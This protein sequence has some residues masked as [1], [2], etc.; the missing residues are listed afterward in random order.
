MVETERVD[1]GFFPS[2]VSLV[3]LAFDL[4]HQ[5]SGV[6]NTIASGELGVADGDRRP[7][8]G[9]PVALLERVERVLDHLVGAVAVTGGD[10]AP[11][12]F[13]DVGVSCRTIDAVPSW[14]P[15]W[16]RTPGEAGIPFPVPR[17]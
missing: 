15:A 2:T 9:E 11:D 10:L 5:L 3:G 16:Q 6:R 12:Q 17:R 4:V 13:R 14:R 8:P 7:E 1:A